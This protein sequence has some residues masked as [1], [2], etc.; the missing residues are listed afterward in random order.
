MKFVVYSLRDAAS[1]KNQSFLLF[2]TAVR[3][4]FEAEERDIMQPA[5]FKKDYYDRCIFLAP[6]WNKYVVD[7]VRLSCP[8]LSKHFSFYGPVDG[9]FTLNV[10]YFNLLKNMEVITTSKWCVEQIRKSGAKVDGFCYHG[11]NHED[12]KFKKEQIIQQRQH[13]S[14]ENPDLYVFFSNCN[15]IHRKGFHHLAKALKLMEQTGRTDYVFVLH[16]GKAKALAIAPELAKAQHLIIEDLYNT[17]PFRQIALKT[18][19]C[20]C[21]VMPSLLE[22]FG[23][24]LLESAAAERPAIFID[25]APMNEI[26]S[27]VEG[28]PIPFTSIKQ[29]EWKAPQC[30]AQLHDY[31]P[32]AL[33]DAMIHVLD[34]KEEAREKGKRARKRSEDFDYWKVYKNFV[35]GRVK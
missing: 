24:P 29:E 11:I 14:K 33:A 23:L 18:A 16:T 35:K 15:P 21:F 5:D 9:P 27:P 4:G 19:S 22:G 12:F 1:F 26:L 7:A 2:K 25:S 3:L 32:Q 13:W 6:L 17:L 10:S 8:W 34:H 28:Y 30:Y 20:D 31:D